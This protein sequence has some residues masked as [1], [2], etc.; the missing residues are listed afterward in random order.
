MIATPIE[1]VTYSF[2]SWN[3]GSSCFQQTIADC[4][5]IKIKVQENEHIIY[6]EIRVLQVYFIVSLSLSKS[7]REHIKK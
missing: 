1:Q 2:E 4:W 7:T 3:V 5:R 6:K